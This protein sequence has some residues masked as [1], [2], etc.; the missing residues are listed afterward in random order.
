MIDV[1]SSTPAS[2]RSSHN[3][4]YA[5]LPPQYMYDAWPKIWLEFDYRL[6]LEKVADGLGVMWEILRKAYHYP[7]DPP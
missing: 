2:R 5:L 1:S 4:K 6:A 7:M 3:E